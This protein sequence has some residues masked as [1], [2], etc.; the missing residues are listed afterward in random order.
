MPSHSTIN[1]PLVSTFA[2]LRAA[3]GIGSLLAPSLSAHFFGINSN[4]DSRIVSR[5]FGA[6]ELTLGVL[7]WRAYVAAS[8]GGVRSDNAVAGRSLASSELLKILWVGVI[9][10][11]VDVVSSV[12]SVFE[13]SMGGKAVWWVGVGAAGACGLG[14]LSLQSV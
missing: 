4:F 9:L 10:D 7:L 11:G 3:V 5:L 12:V 14:L 2:V 13:G 1:G 8:S 6:R